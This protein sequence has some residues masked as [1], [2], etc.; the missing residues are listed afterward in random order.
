MGI[1]YRHVNTNISS[2]YSEVCDLFF[3]ITLFDSKEISTSDRLLEA[4]SIPLIE[5]DQL[6]KTAYIQ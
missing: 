1:P 3:A 4:N 6:K 5:S 2:R